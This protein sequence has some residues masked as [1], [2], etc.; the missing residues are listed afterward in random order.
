MQSFAGRCRF[1]TIVLGLLLAG[2][3]WGA[4][5][6]GTAGRPGPVSQVGTRMAWRVSLPLRTVDAVRYYELLEGN[7]YAITTNG[8]V[9]CIQADSGQLLW[10]RQLM[11]PPG[12]IYPPVV[13]RS[14]EFYGVAFTLSTEVVLLDPMT[15]S[16]F[17]RIRLISPASASAT[18]SAGRIYAAETNR[19][20][21]AYDLKDN[22]QAWQIMTEGPVE[23]APIYQ[24]DLETLVLVDLTGVIAMVWGTDKEEVYVRRLGGEPQGEIAADDAHF[25][26]STANSVVHCVDRLNGESV[27]EHRLPDRPAGGPVV[28]NGSVYQALTGGGL[29]RI[30]MD[31]Q[32]PNWLNPDARQFLAEW[33]GQ[34]VLLYRDGRVVAVDPVSGE[35]AA[36]IDAAPAVSGIANTIN[37][38]LLLTTPSG[39]IRCIQPLESSPATLATFRPTTTQPTSQPTTRPALARKPPPPENLPLFV[40]SSG[41]AQQGTG[42]GASAGSRSSRSSRGDRSS[43]SSRSSSRGSRGD[44][45]SSRGSRGSGGS[46]GSR[47]S[48]GGGSHGGGASG[49]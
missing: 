48:R 23:V 2:P 7:L 13:Y 19:R 42:G 39:D 5:T 4:K 38:G 36:V 6:T 8:M 43:S 25:Y 24:P 45:S 14:P 40:R 27:W 3:A 44:R 10:S 16:E 37:D 15:G 26:I 33:S 1:G 46:R 49:G 28:V 21:R 41:N 11:A 30:G 9:Y 22:Y 35:P 31:P 20:I 12:T 17:N 32:R 34:P 29:Q 18:A 47:G